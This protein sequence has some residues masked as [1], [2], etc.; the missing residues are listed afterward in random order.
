[1]Q[2]VQVPMRAFVLLALSTFALAGE[3]LITLDYVGG[4]RPARVSKDPYLAI[5]KDGTIRARNPLTKDKPRTDKM[6][7]ETVKKLVSELAPKVK[8]PKK[9]PKDVLQ[10]TDASTTVIRVGKKTAK[11]YALGFLA[12]KLP[13]HKQV[14]ALWAARNR[15]DVIYNVTMAGGA[16]TARSTSIRTCTR[17]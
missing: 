5:Y 1:M 10:I 3:P 17:S 8:T 6:A 15:L 4:I 7:K 12:Q 9:L 2:F 14:Q 11:Q 16:K 13:K